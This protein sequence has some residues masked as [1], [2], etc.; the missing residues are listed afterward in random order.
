MRSMNWWLWGLIPSWQ[1]SK[2][3]P[4]RFHGGVICWEN[5][6][7]AVALRLF[8]RAS[9]FLMGSQMEDTDISWLIAATK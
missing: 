6:T 4:R 7:L 9:I 5:Q 8:S 1:K 2:R 3:K